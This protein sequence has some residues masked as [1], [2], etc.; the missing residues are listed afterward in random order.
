M[1]G[2]AGWR[3]GPLA[4]HLADW[5][6]FAL[7]S[8]GVITLTLLGV[9]SV[10]QHAQ[11]QASQTLAT[12]ASFK[13]QQL[14]DWVKERE[15]DANN[16]R[17]SALLARE[18]VAA[19]QGNPQARTILEQ[20]LSQIRKLA[21]YSGFDL[22]GADGVG[23]GAP[24]S[25][26][27]VAL[28]PP[29]RLALARWDA[30]ERLL[31]G[32]YR[33]T[34]G[35]PRLA[36]LARMNAEPSIPAWVVL[37]IDPT[38]WLEPT[39]HRW[40]V[41]TQTGTSLL[42]RGSGAD[43][44]AVGDG[45]SS[46]STP[47]HADQL[48]PLLERWRAG[49]PQASVQAPIETPQGSKLLTAG[50][51]VGGTDWWVL[52]HIAETEVQSQAQGSVL[53]VLGAGLLALLL[54][55]SLFVLQRQRLNA[56]AA[57]TWRAEHEERLRLLELL[58]GVANNSQDLIFAKDLSGR[59]TLINRAAAQILTLEPAQVLGRTDRELLPAG[60]ADAFVA[61]DN[62]VVT[63]MRALNWEQTL[64][65]PGKD[66]RVLSV[67][68]APL[69]STTGALLGVFGI[70]RDISAAKAS[71]AALR[72]SESRLSLALRGG[73]LGLWDW[74]LV[75][76]RM[77]VNERWKTMLGMAPDAEVSS[78][79]A[80]A[81]RVHPDDQARLQHLASAIFEAPGQ[82]D[83]SIEV[84]ARTQAGDW[85][86]IHDSGAVVARDTQGKA[87]RA[88]GTHADVTTRKNVLR[89]LQHERI[90]LERILDGTDVGTWEWN[91]QTG[92]VRFNE[93]WAEMVGYTLEA[94]RPI[95]IDTWSRLCHPDDLLRSRALLEAHYRGEQATYQCEVRMQHQRGHWVWV[96]DRGKLFSRDEQGRP[97]WMAGTHTDITERK[98]A[99][100]ELSR[101]SLA[102]E[103][104]PT[105]III[106]DLQ[107]RIE[108]VNETFT[109]VS[110]YGAPEVLGRNP[111]LL[112]SGL[113]PPAVTAEL[114]STLNA[115]QR[116]KGELV[117]RRKD[118][119]VYTEFVSI[120]PLRQTDGT[121]THFVSVQEDIT[122]KRAMREELAQYRHHLEELV[123]QRTSELN[124]AMRQAEVA[125]QSKSEFLANMS[126]EIRTP[127]NAILGL[128]HLIEQD[129][130]TAPDA[131]RRL[132][133]PQLRDRARKID[134]AAK[135]LLGILN[136]VLD[137]SKIEAGKLQIEVT[138]FD[139]RELVDGVI[140][141]VSEKAQ[142]N[143]NQ[144]TTHLGQA[145]RRLSG[146]GMRLGQI[147]LNFLSNAVKF[148]ERGEV[149]LSVRVVSPDAAPL[150]L[151]FEV[152]D[153][154]VGLNPEQCARLFQPFEQA[155]SSTTRRFGGTGLGLAIVQRLAQLMGGQV[156][157]SSRSGRG[158]IFWFE[159]PFGQAT[160]GDTPEGRAAAPANDD[161]LGALRRRH[162]QVLLVEDTPVNQE[163]ALAM[164]SN[165]GLNA[166]LA[167]N[168][169]R[170]VHMAA[171]RPYDL[172]L[173][174]L[175]MPLMD[176]F[177][178][179]RAIRNLPQHA[180]TPI[181]AMTANAFAEDR[182]A[183][184]AA[185]MNDHIGKPVLPDVLYAM[186]LKWLP[187]RKA[188]V[189]PASATAP[190]AEA[191]R[192]GSNLHAALAALPGLDLARG[193]ATLG[194]KEDKLVSL[195]GKF[196]LS[197]QDA[198]PAIEAAVHHNDWAG[199]ARLAHTLRGSGASLGLMEVSQQATLAEAAL[200][201]QHLPDLKPLERA[202]KRV[203][204][205]LCELAA[206][207]PGPA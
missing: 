54:A 206:T 92:Q 40:P 185:G 152:L 144:V 41:P 60:E 20:R 91:V 200:L 114:W 7:L 3:F 110:G 160:Q 147:L 169:R 123:L 124:E 155:E 175:R 1:R 187:E 161:V 172:I 48:R 76:D 42:L 8:L 14:H 180:R 50:H 122:E 34:Q 148:T 188:P 204:P 186:L 47:L 85:I 88:V 81:E 129:L 196:A 133:M 162:A 13:A 105:S 23:V 22:V 106:T 103:Q 28:E 174:D 49:A 189:R 83:F 173:M 26:P 137:L 21:D 150:R 181:L 69:K 182:A 30:S 207:P 17:S 156:G 101:L 120:H 100:Q 183:A 151:R 89:E 179:T 202:L 18:Y 157:A 130:D 84:R 107:A 143:G 111:R 68:K 15:A 118:G 205:R 159:A 97:E 96:Q 166:D 32:P 116:W 136:D 149:H 191:P 80:W 95:S 112:S 57:S 131:E 168:G 184:L 158:S 142:A 77:E 82:D 10:L 62:Q 55:W 194:G 132:S 25:D 9:R 61:Q 197:Y 78:H 63:Q 190:G 2:P 167:P 153:T 195:L 74:D 16:F 37:R 75:S 199:A 4:Q 38:R 70:A 65:Q 5:R 104:S 87:L 94:L 59:Y 98:L 177:E 79:A 146:D 113:T 35:R 66:Q 127:M 31:F 29:L 93:R 193:L 27:A 163:I 67:T 109:R 128:T 99:E 52:T 134:Q 138:D 165:A 36:L 141:M 108:Y 170:A 176:G 44:M 58:E 126:H 201:E 203:C 125:S 86:W 6:S 121:V 145:P 45:A 164:L 43:F 24:G 178:A 192:P 72:D 135:H 12:V 73:D 139:L 117:N 102:V 140:Y 46:G 119:T 33:D 171:E 64:A 198:V 19:V 53:Q 51:P 115:G 11:D 90:R 154:G 56:L 39:L 71:E